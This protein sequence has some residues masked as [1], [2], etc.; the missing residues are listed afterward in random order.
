M[1]LSAQPKHD[2]N[3]FRGAHPDAIV[4][5]LNHKGL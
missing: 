3:G 5:H 4:F 1:N 2:K